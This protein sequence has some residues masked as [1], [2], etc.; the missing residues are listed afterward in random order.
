MDMIDLKLQVIILY[1]LFIAMFWYLYIRFY[2]NGSDF[3]FRM[4]MMLG[5]SLIFYP[6]AI[7]ILH[8]VGLLTHLRDFMIG[9]LILSLVLT[10]AYELRKRLS[11][12]SIAVILWLITLTAIL[13]I[14]SSVF[15]LLKSGVGV[16][17]AYG[18]SLCFVLQEAYEQELLET[19]KRKLGCR[20]WFDEE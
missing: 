20:G 8:A 4:V 14:P 6:L 19:I 2:K 18:L 13:A 11:R 12:C 10:I 5:L 9:H 15:I 16:I 1:F 17:I 3:Y 7:L